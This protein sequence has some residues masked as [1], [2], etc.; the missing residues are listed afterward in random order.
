MKLQNLWNEAVVKYLN[1]WSK[2]R[3]VEFVQHNANNKT[4]AKK[5]LTKLFGA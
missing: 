1:G 2:S 4:Q 5:I 3:I